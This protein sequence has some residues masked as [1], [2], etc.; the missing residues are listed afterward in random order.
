VDDVHGIVSKIS[1]ENE[2]GASELERAAF[3]G[4][5]DPGPG[6][7]FEDAMPNAALAGDGDMVAACVEGGAEV[8]EIAAKSAGIGFACQME[9]SQGRPVSH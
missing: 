2:C 8:E 7:A 5:V 1:A 3:E 4:G 9:Y 6:G